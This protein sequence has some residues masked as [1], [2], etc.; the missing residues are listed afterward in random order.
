MAIIEHW[1]EAVYSQV[2]TDESR[3]C[4]ASAA[5]KLAGSLGTFGLDT[6]SAFAST[7][8]EM[9]GFDLVE[10]SNGFEALKALPSQHFDMIIT[11]LNMP[12]INGLE[13]I[14]FVKQN[15]GKSGIIYCLSRK[16]VE[17][18]AQTLSVNGIRALPYH[19]G[20]EAPVRA[21]TRTGSS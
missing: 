11:D 19:A 13:I 6:G 9:N 12:D 10:A 8:E 7:I 14:K 1:L 2:L 3:T 20:L 16:K 15:Q 5:H 4:A 17:E 18:V 21:A